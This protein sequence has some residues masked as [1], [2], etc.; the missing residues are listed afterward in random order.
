VARLCQ[1]PG[2]WGPGGP[3]VWLIGHCEGTALH[4]H[5]VDSSQLVAAAAAE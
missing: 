4:H 5:C 3:S 1:R 2:L